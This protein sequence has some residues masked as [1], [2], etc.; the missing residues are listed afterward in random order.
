MLTIFDVFLF[1]FWSLSWS[2]WNWL[3]RTSE[4]TCYFAFWVGM[5]TATNRNQPQPTA[6]N[7]VAVF[8]LYK[9]RNHPYLTCQPQKTA[10]RLVAVFIPN[11]RYKNRNQTGY[12]LDAVGCS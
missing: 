4:Y 5:K 9:N 12:R 11:I 2:L 8:I 1:L 7:L 10:T 3:T 6:T